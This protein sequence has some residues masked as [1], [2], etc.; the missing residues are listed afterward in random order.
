[1][2][3]KSCNDITCKLYA[4]KNVTPAGSQ[5]KISSIMEFEYFSF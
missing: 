4:T 1:M 3:A 5:D 2:T